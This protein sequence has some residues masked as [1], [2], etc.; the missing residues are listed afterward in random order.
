MNNQF[1]LNKEYGLVLEGGG[2]KGA[3]QIGVWKALL[4][5]GVKIKGVAGVSVGALNG[6]LICMGDYDGA[7]KL[8]SDITYSTI[9][10]VNDDT[11]DKLVNG[12][13]KDLDIKEVAKDT[14]KTLSDGGI[15]ITPLKDLINR[16]VDEDKIQDSEIEFILGTVLVPKLK[17]VEI[18]AK[19]VDK[20]YL[21]DYLL[22]SS[23]LPAFRNEKLHGTRY[24]D[25]GMLN[26]VPINMLINRGYKDIIVIRIYGIGHER[27]VKIPEDVT[28]IEIAPRVNLGG[29]L[30]F[31]CNKSRRNIKIGYY[32]GLR[33]LLALKGKIYYIDSSQSEDEYL[34][35]LI[36]VNTSVKM[37][38]LEFYRLDTINEKTYTR[39]F[40]EQVCPRIATTL[41]LN[42]DWSYEDLYIS[43]LELCAKSLKIQKYKVYTIEELRILIIDKYQILLLKG[44]KF[45]F[46]HEIILDMVSCSER[47][48][49]K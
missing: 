4:E 6:A 11:M 18:S 34:N 20:G 13:F 28:V 1:D 26:N 21:K 47:I 27:Q 8:W 41:K 5:M 22:A 24:M 9:M 7:E 40:I 33:C 3:Y 17:E 49:I 37:A 45:P 23:C 30:E 2:A 31:D 14:V 12:N 15:D 10:K 38:L 35:K 32:D 36:Q 39:K 19:E 43:L 29:I 42:K 48:L 16:W 46:F 25:G 44:T